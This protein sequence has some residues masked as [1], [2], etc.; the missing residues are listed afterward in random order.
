MQFPPR[1][2][3]SGPQP[4]PFINDMP[5]SLQTGVPVVQLSVPAWQG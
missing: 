2:T 3:K 4:T 5:V 1:H